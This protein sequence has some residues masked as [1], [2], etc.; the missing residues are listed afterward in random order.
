MFFVEHQSL[1]QQIKDGKSHQ[2]LHEAQFV[3][4]LCQY[5]LRQEYQP[6]QITIL[7]TYTGQLFCL[8][9]LMP[10]K[11]FEGVKV[12]VVDKYQGEEND[13]VILSLVRS[14]RE[15]KVGFLQIPNRVCVALSRAKKGLYCIG[16]MGLFSK[17]KLWSNILHTL[18][19]R[20]QVGPELTLS[21]QN[22]SGTQTQV[23]S[24]QD[25]LNVPEGGCNRPCEYRLDCGHVCTRMCHPYD[26]E[27]KTFKCNKECPKIICELQHKC[28]KLC[29]QECGKCRFIVE[30]VIPQCQHTQQMPCHQDPA[31]FVCKVPCKKTLSCGHICQ[32]GC[33]DLCTDFC[34]ERVL[35]QLK[36]GHNQKDQCGLFKDPEDEP[37]CWTKCE[38]QLKC[39]HVCTGTCHACYQGRLHKSCK[40]KCNRVL[41]CSHECNVPCT[42]TCPPCDHLCQNRCVH[43]KCKKKCG[44]PCSPCN[45]PCQWKCAHIS[46]SKLCH[47]PCDRPPCYEKC[48]K[49][50]KCGH[51]CIGLCGDPCPKKCRIC[52][53]D[54][55][56]E[57]F[58]GREDEPDAT[59]IH[60]EDCKHIIEASAMDVIMGMDASQEADLDQRAIR[61]KACPRCRTPIRRNMRY[62]THVNRSLAEI[63]KVKEQINGQPSEIKSKQKELL[64]HLKLKVNLKQQFTIQYY[65]IHETLER[66]G[67]SLADLWHQENLIFFLE[68]LGKLKKSNTH[69][70]GMFSQR[71]EECLNFLLHRSQR[72]TD[73]QMADIER[74]IKRLSLF[75]DLNVRCERANHSVLQNV[76]SQV[77]QARMILE[78]T[79]PFSEATEVKVKEI[80]KELE[81]MLPRTGLGISNEERVMIVKAMNLNKGHWYKCINGHVYAIGDCGGAMESRRCPECDATI[82]GA[83]HTLAQGN[84]VATEMDGAQHPAW[85]NANNVLNFDLIDLQ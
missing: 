4:A 75:A 15:G 49:M 80:L 16:N 59:F 68:K 53:H 76:N 5:F 44:Q 63:E 40:N 20:N 42:S 81:I 82:G 10:K 12:H 77:T 23:S 51:P 30:K 19:E 36:C 18:R 3:V 78:D 37:D 17:V 64:L 52:D 84:S 48:H 28:M 33:G 47:E 1:E 7:T 41:P 54:E 74:E 31:T 13:I 38:A 11:E 71:F 58:L 67:L 14:N 43:S 55:V 73:Q 45:E 62:G 50:L 35:K 34:R 26:A 8:R 57:I 72:F 32:A 60:L 29:Y 25:F 69:R 27:H 9:N 21:C 79:R 39:G 85:S 65:K 2:N 61:L 70:S 24:A 6:S 83:Q 66:T 22:H 56:T 46:C